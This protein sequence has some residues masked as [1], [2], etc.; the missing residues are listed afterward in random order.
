MLFK[1]SQLGWRLLVSSLKV[2]RQH[3]KWLILPLVGSGF[4]F[5]IILAIAGLAWALRTGMVDYHRFSASQLAWGYLVLLLLL[6]FGNIVSAYF[7]AAAMVCLCAYDHGLE[8]SLR[9]GLRAAAKRLVT[10]FYWTVAHFIFAIKVPERFKPLLS[11]LNWRSASFLIPPLIVNEP[12]GFASTLRRSSQLMRASAGKYPQMNFT[13]S[14]FSFFLRLLCLI[15]ITVGL[16][17]HT[18]PWMIT[19]AAITFILLLALVV[20][21]K[22]ILVVI[23]QAIYEWVAHH[24]VLRGFCVEDI[25]TAI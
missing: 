25:S 23:L 18:L 8:I 4:F 2:V 13:Y 10:I 16:T 17:I 21:L 12:A 24:K 6:W 7:N 9:K 1:K 19:G 15:P 5:S 22:T 20:A 14:W 3:K 11:E